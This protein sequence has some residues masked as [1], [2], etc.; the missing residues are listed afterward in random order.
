MLVCESVTSLLYPFSWSVTNFS[1]NIYFN[2]D[3]EYYMCSETV[4][5]RPHVYVPI[6]PPAL[7]TFLDAPVPYIMGLLR[8]QYYYD[9][10]LFNFESSLILF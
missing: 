6:L 2:K 8:Y 5:F 1:K 10:N 3:E 4:C 9:L 7:E